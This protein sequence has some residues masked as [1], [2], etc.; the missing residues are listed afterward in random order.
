[1]L[2]VGL[3]GS[4]YSGKSTISDLFRKIK[5]PVFDSD[6]ILKYILRYDYKVINEICNKIGHEYIKNGVF[7]TDEILADNKFKDIVKIA[8]P[9]IL[10]SYYKFQDKHKGSV[11]TIFKSSILFE[12]GI[13]NKMDK[14]ISINC[15]LD[16]RLKRLYIKKSI[17]DS[18]MKFDIEQLLK[19]ENY[20]DK[21]N[22]SDIIIYN[23]GIFDV[24]NQV[25]RADN[26]IVDFY[27]KS[28]IKQNI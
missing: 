16:E 9:H 22:N 18:F 19:S 12:S 21:V 11:Y 5:V 23:F 17:K 1:M 3:T 28:K 15:P 13:S 24:N 20:I 8:S 25:K 14:I 27:L 6:V 26:D 2:K 7:N 10:N 4:R